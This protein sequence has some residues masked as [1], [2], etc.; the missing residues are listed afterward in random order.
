MYP[1]IYTRRLN[2]DGQW[3]DL[4]SP[5]SMRRP[6]DFEVD[7]E[8]RVWWTKIT[9]FPVNATITIQG[10]LRPAILMTYVRLNVIFPGG[11]KHISSGLY[12]VT[13]QQDNISGSGYRTTLSLVKISGDN[14]D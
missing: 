5:T 14:L 1:E 3:E 10:L 4:Y 8:D 11:H 13:K 12:I 6:D 7:A 2:E 9:K